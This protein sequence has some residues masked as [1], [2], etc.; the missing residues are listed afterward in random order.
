MFMDKS[1]IRVLLKARLY[2]KQNTFTMNGHLS[3]LEVKALNPMLEN[4]AFM[5]ATPEKLMP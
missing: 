4:S 1:Q 5:V 3:D 2:D